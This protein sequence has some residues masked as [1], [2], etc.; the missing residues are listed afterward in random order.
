MVTIDGTTT[1]YDFEPG[2]PATKED[3]KNG[4]FA[5]YGFANQGQCIRFVNTGQDSRG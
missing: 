4:G 3:C 1:V 5:D 2:S